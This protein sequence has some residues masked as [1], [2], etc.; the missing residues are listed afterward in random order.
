MSWMST[1]RMR[2]V[3]LE[4]ILFGDTGRIAGETLER[5]KAAGVMHV[6]AA[7]GANVAFVLAL[8]WG[9]FFLYAA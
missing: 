6:F 9:I 1:G 3:I 4:G 7:S 2:Q 8:V 5:Y